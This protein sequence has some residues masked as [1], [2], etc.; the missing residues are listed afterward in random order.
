M[1]VE[2]WVFAIFIFVM[3]LIGGSILI[4]AYF[5]RKEDFVDHL[6]KKLKGLCNGKSK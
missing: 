6:N 5:R 1:L 2:A 4:D 3:A